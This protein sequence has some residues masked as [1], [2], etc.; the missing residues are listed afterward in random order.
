MAYTVNH[1]DVANKGSIIVEDNTINT[2]T[3]LQLPGRN[4]T[5]YG[6]AIRK[7]FTLI[8]KFCF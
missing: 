2:Q 3:S 4:T 5:A 1:T 7:L 8:R 6:I